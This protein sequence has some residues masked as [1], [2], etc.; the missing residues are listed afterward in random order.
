MNLNY[1]NKRVLVTGHTGFKG[2]W[3]TL[4][5]DMLGAKVAGYSLPNNKFNN[6]SHFKS[7]KF[8]NLKDY[9]GD[10][11]NIKKVQNVFT[12]FN[13][14]IVFH[15]AAQPIVRESYN[16]PHSTMSTNIMGGLSV[17][18]CV[19]KSKS[20]KSLVYITSDKCYENKE[21]IWGYREHDELGG[22]DPYSA[23]KSG[24]EMIFNSYLR[25]FY[26]H[27]KMGASSAR[28][29]NVI[30]GGD[31]SSDRIIPDCIKSIIDKKIL[32]IRSPNATRPW[33]HVLE[34]LSGY[35]MLANVH[36]KYKDKYNGSWNFG[37]DIQKNITVKDITEMLFKKLNHDKLLKFTKNQSK[38]H[39]ANL[40]QLNC[41]KAKQLL[42]WNPRWDVNQTINKTAE[43][44]KSFINGENMYRV[45]RNQIKEYF[46]EINRWC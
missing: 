36:F 40:L 37:P 2:S 8:N 43:W 7:L 24:A 15:L 12:E 5:L 17:L 20:V 31:W 16:D 19:R 30:G 44:Y 26:T 1:K 4:I 9:R 10:I 41:D 32:E 42:D 46:Y 13:P 29:G 45:T 23:S 11:S 22:I 6:D 34:P 35:L 18:E 21:W 3:L 33:Q 25:S 38:A 14:Q 39:E 27:K 28:A